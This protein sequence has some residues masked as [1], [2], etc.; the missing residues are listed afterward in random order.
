MP[1]L[2]VSGFFAHDYAFRKAAMAS[3]SGGLDHILIYIGALIQRASRFF[4][5][6]LVLGGVVPALVG[7]GLFYAAFRRKIAFR[8][9]ITLL[10]GGMS[11]N[12]QGIFL[13]LLT[14][15]TGSN[16]GFNYWQGGRHIIK[17]GRRTFEGWIAFLETGA[18]IFGFGALGG[19]IFWR[20]IRNSGS[21]RGY[22]SR[23]EPGWHG[24]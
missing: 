21:G 11:A 20:I 14:A 5:F 19:L 10:V 4:M 1:T 3:G 23:Q 9:P 2:L 22:G 12:I 24:R 16:S 17:D 8:L 6:G 7:S 13:A 18:I 15:M